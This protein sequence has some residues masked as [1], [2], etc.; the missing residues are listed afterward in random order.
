MSLISFLI[1]AGKAIVAFFKSDS[2]KAVLKIAELAAPI[3][4]KQIAPIHEQERIARDLFES[5]LKNDPDYARQY[6]LFWQSRIAVRQL[7]QNGL[8]DPKLITD[9]NINAA[10]ELSY[11]ASKRT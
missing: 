3:V 8:V 2:G 6:I 10:T 4:K 9:A 1:G 11:S 5:A 7:M